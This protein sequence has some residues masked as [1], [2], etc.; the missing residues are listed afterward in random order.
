MIRKTIQKM[1]TS[2]YILLVIIVIGTIL[3]ALSKAENLWLLFFGL[4]TAAAAGLTLI[5]KKF[6][7]IL[8]LPT[9]VLLGTSLI[10]FNRLGF[11]PNLFH[12]QFIEPDQFN[13]NLIVVYKNE[14]KPSQSLKMGVAS[15]D[16]N[17]SEA[18][19]MGIVFKRHPNLT[20]TDFILNDYS[21]QADHLTTSWYWS[22]D[23]TYIPLL[24]YD[25]FVIYDPILVDQ[26]PRDG[27]QLQLIERLELH[28]S[29]ID[30]TDTTQ[31][32]KIPMGDIHYLSQSNIID[33]KSPLDWLRVDFSPETSSLSLQVRVNGNLLK[34]QEQGV[35]WQTFTPFDEIQQIFSIEITESGRTQ[36]F[37]LQVLQPKFTSIYI[38]EAYPQPILIEA[39]ELIKF[40]PRLNRS[41][42][43]T[44][45]DSDNLASQFS[46]IDAKLEIK[47]GIAYV[48]PQGF[49]PTLVYRVAPTEIAASGIE[50]MLSLT[51]TGYFLLTAFFLIMLTISSL[52]LNHSD[53]TIVPIW[54][55]AHKQTKQAK[56][57]FSSDWFKAILTP[58]N[59]VFLI[60]LLLS[61]SLILEI[62]SSSVLIVFVLLLSLILIYY[63]FN[64]TTLFK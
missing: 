62:I 27:T 26:I 13:P 42:S 24:E 64:R 1:G 17:L 44:T 23:Q 46:T 58:F 14:T 52:L 25:S 43:F 39:I 48:H 30:Q 59:V 49:E 4:G 15:P 56:E 51:F 53:Q 16:L 57:R 32:Q 45:W 38:S 28:L 11:E 2:K 18:S 19:K 34:P 61:W 20:A 7:H 41:L 40:F 35:D 21:I 54:V 31:T 8:I 36:P 33:L 47:Q 3:T 50:R 22:G 6:A 5:I 37:A 63:I 55:F 29:E 60:F 9:L 12:I 10:L